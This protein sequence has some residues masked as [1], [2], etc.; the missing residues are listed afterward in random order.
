MGIATNVMTTETM[1]H[2]DLNN[3]R[4][5]TTILEL[6]DRSKVIPEGILEDITIPLD[7]WEYHINFLILHPKKNLGGHP[8]ILGKSWLAIVDAFMGCRSGSIII[9][10]GDDRKHITLYSPEQ[11]PSLVSIL[12][13]QEQ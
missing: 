3:I 6:A 13:G 12:K 11:A 5:T 4:S 7:S 8:L 10:H 1:K 9:A 2:L